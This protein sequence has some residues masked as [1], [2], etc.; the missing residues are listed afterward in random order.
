MNQD[1]KIFFSRRLTQHGK[2]VLFCQGDR[3]LMEVPLSSI[4]TAVKVVDQLA[5]EYNF[6]VPEA[7]VTISTDGDWQVMIHKWWEDNPRILLRQYDGD[8]T[9]AS[10]ESEEIT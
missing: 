3:I 2:N 1:E 9:L 5:D 7:T 4:E 6:G 10:W 8:T